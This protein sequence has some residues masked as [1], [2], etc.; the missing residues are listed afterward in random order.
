MN[1]TMYMATRDTLRILV[2]KAYS[3][4][5]INILGTDASFNIDEKFCIVHIKI[6]LKGSTSFSFAHVI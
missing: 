6:F 5:E 1:Q 2:E 4:Q 3:Y